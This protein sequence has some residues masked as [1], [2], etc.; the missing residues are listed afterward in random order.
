M[1]SGFAKQDLYAAKAPRDATSTIFWLCNG[2]NLAAAN[3][4]KRK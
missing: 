4:I 3:H 1:Y 2:F